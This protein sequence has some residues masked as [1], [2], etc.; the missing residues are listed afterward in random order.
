MPI[1]V[2]VMGAVAL[3]AFTFKGPLQDGSS[4]G[5]SPRGGGH[6]SDQELVQEAQRRGLT[7]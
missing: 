1:E 3:I 6:M 4:G 5:G 7:K 2:I